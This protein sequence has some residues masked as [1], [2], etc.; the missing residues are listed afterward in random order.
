MGLV[1]GNA[2]QDAKVM[3]DTAPASDKVTSGLGDEWLVHE[4]TGGKYWGIKSSVRVLGSGCKHYRNSEARK[5]TGEKSKSSNFERDCKKPLF[6]SRMSAV[7]SGSY[8]PGKTELNAMWYSTPAR[9]IPAHQTLRTAY[10][11]PREEY[12]AWTLESSKIV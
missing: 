7:N 6:L 10:S 11:P 3:E 5:I 8:H 1:Q 12:L 4:T 2:I 9:T